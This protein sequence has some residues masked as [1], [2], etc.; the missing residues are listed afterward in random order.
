MTERRYSDEEVARIF[1]EAT[2]KKL[3]EGASSPPALPAPE[4][5]TLTQLQE[6]G[7]EVGLSPEAVAAGAAMVEVGAAPVSYTGATLGLPHGVSGSIPLPRELTDREWEIL[8]GR[9]RDTFQAHGTL[10]S[11]GMSR[12][13]RNGN[14]HIRV[15]PTATGTVLRMG[16]HKGDGKVLPGIGGGMVG[17][18]GLLSL[19][20]GTTLNDPRGAGVMAAL[21]I[22]VGVLMLGLGYIT[23]PRWAR[24]R[25]AQMEEIAGFLLRMTSEPPALPEGGET[26]ERDARGGRDGPG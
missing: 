23:V 20:M 11:E 26:G 24:K 8:V 4:G 3:A 18:G 16:T 14:L 5:L 13:W 7:A 21:F 1:E 2:R 6:I 17:A 19:L 25:K 10:E 9:L 22:P 15:E 12:S